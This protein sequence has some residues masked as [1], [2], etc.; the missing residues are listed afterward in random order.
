MK[1]LVFAERYESGAWRDWE[2]VCDEDEL[3]AVVDSACAKAADSRRNPP[4]FVDY[5][6]G[7]RYIFDV[8][9]G[10]GDSPA[11]GDTR[12]YAAVVNGM[13]V[14]EYLRVERHFQLKIYAA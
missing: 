6:F 11:E 9:R 2:H 12:V 3:E 14:G 7:A 5:L 4:V 10:H 8:A 13:L 1:I